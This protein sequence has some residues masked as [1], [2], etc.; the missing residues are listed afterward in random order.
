MTKKRR[1][2]LAV[3]LNILTIALIIATSLG[4]A[5]FVIRREMNESYNEL[6]QH[7]ISIAYMAAENCEYAIYTK[8]SEALEQVISSVKEDKSVAYF[9]IIDKEN[10]ILSENIFIPSIKIP[11]NI[12]EPRTYKYSNYIEFI[13]PINGKRYI[14]VYAPVLSASRIGTEPML[15]TQINPDRKN[16]IGHIQLGLTIEGLH[17]RVRGFLVS[18]VVFTG[19]IV[20]M[21]IIF[22]VLMTRK[23][24]S[25]LRELAL[26]TQDI[27][28]GNFEHRVVVKSNDELA[29]LALAFNRML[30]RLRSYREQVQEY[31]NE[32]EEALD[33][34]S[35]LAKQA[36]DA[37]T[38]KSQF[39][40]NMSHEIRTPL[41]GVLGMAELLMT[42]DLTGRQRNLAETILHSGKTLL[43]VLN[44]ILDFSKIEMGK[45]ELA[46]SEFELRSLVEE[47]ECVNDFETPSR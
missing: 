43:R 10:T 29:D 25:P 19:F 35:L 28:E 9:S 21:G 22:T 3:K 41:N 46:N 39:L 14:N 36:T 20:V 32:L 27:S 13:S 15:E 1:L 6:L 44:D 11:P 17:D 31:Q 18:T 5:L 30:G 34:K 8:N 33:E 2:N 24:A 40:A 4:V 38:A 45:L 26:L 47:A 37:S 7:G 42:T 16:V 23:I 12:Y